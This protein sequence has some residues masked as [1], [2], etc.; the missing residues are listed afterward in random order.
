MVFVFILNIGRGHT[1]INWSFIRYQQCTVRS[2][3][4]RLETWKRVPERR[5]NGRATLDPC[6]ALPRQDHLTR[7]EKLV[8]R[9]VCVKYS[10]KNRVFSTMTSDKPAPYTLR[11]LLNPTPSKLR[12][13]DKFWLEESNYSLSFL[14]ITHSEEYFLVRRERILWGIR[15]PSQSR[16]YKLRRKRVY[17]RSKYYTMVQSIRE[18]SWSLN[19]GAIE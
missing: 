18:I 19:L 16:S 12:C 10:H 13:N 11:R 5:H 6:H 4:G 17:T 1:K 7:S 14:G 2:R 9:L 3:M 15:V 8:N